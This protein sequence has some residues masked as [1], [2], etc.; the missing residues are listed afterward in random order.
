MRASGGEAPRGAPKCAACNCLLTFPTALTAGALPHLVNQDN[1][2][3]R[4]EQGQQGLEQRLEH[5][6]QE[7]LALKHNK[8]ARRFNRSSVTAVGHAALQPLRREE[9]AAAGGAHQ[10]G[11]L[12]PPGIFPADTAALSE[13][14]NGRPCQLRSLALLGLV[15]R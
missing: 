8:R 2:L 7:L 11:A 10:L 6:E 12:P 3:Q 15:L 1:V 5:L 4:L 14:G 9:E 13:V